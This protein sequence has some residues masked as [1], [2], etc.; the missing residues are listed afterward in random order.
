[1]SERYTLE[2]KI[3][4]GNFG[5]VFSGILKVAIKRIPK[6]IIEEQK[7]NQELER[8]KN[9]LSKFK[10]KNIIKLYDFIETE[11]YY[12]LILEKCDTDLNSILEKKHKGFSIIE[13]RNI[14]NQLKLLKYYILII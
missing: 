5:K 6:S 9:I 13:I 8:E 11:N 3:G 12:D 2:N 10:S 1:M 14:M 7:L 4:E